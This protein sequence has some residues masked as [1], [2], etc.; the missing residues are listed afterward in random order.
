MVG[1]RLCIF[2]TIQMG[3]VQS[4]S[5]FEIHPASSRSFI[6]SSMK[7]LF[8]TGMAYSFDATGRPVVDRSISTKFAPPKAAEDLETIHVNSVLNMQSN[9]FLTSCGISTSCSVIASLLL[10]V[11]C[12]W[13]LECF[14]KA[15]SSFWVW[16]S[17]VPV[18]VSS[19]LVFCIFSPRYFMNGVHIIYLVK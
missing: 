4:L 16:G 5:D 8:F 18:L 11:A 13:K 9:W 14:G 10:S 3:D 6:S 1:W 12:I 7:D 17:Q 19:F 2:L 15:G